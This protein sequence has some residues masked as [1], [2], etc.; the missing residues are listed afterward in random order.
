[1]QIPDTITRYI[2]P[3]TEQK[4]ANGSVVGKDDFLK[5]LVTQLRYQDPENPVD[6]KEFTAQLAQFSSLEQMQQI[7]EGFAQ[8]KAI[9][10]EQGKFSLLQAV[11]KTAR[12]IGDSLISD[13]SGQRGL[14]K[15][16]GDAAATSVA[17]TDSAG[18]VV[19]TI[20]LGRLSAGEHPFTWDGTLAGGAGA[21]PGTYHFTVTALDGS[22]KAVPST[23]YMEGPVTGVS[24]GDT[25]TAY[26]A[27]IPV[28]FSQ[29]ALWKGGGNP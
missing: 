8:M 13:A 28:P 26:I 19:R 16:D 17:I 7:S 14:F 11:G 9:L 29:I 22:G 4:K 5:L 10:E 27:G 3:N 12:G 15:L 1:M 24:L 25:P 21:P 18:T 23:S 2:P 6:N 20:D